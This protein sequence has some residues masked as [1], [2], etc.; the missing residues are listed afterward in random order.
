MADAVRKALK[1]TAEM[2]A[3]CRSSR[4]D[5][6]AK[7]EYSTAELQAIEAAF[8]CCCGSESIQVKSAAITLSKLLSRYG[9]SAPLDLSGIKEPQ[10]LSELQAIE[11]AFQCCCGSE[12]HRYKE[13]A[14][15]LSQMLSAYG[16]S[17]AMDLSAIEVSPPPPS[18]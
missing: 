17:V 7:S 12:H 8:R 4:M 18:A 5:N 16:Y 6:C 3:L 2:D 10:L 13:A 15:T 14:T 1:T 11:V 9:Y